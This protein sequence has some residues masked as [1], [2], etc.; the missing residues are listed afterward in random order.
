MKGID[1]WKLLEFATG[2]YKQGIFT[3]DKYTI[4]A[5]LIEK[6]DFEPVFTIQSEEWGEI[7]ISKEQIEEMDVNIFQLSDDELT[8][9]GLNYGQ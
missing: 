4:T 9:M 7:R 8:M 5:K 6:T 2:Y 1:N 3:L